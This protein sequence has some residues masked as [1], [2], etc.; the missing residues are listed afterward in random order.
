MAVRESPAQW[1]QSTRRLPL[2]EP[3]SK[4]KEGPPT[5]SGKVTASL[6]TLPCITRGPFG[7][8]DIT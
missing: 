4:R 5:H 8:S 1:F 6:S 3:H 7:Q 2:H